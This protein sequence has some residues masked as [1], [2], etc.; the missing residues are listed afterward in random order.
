[1]GCQNVDLVLSFYAFST[2]TQA[3]ALGQGKDAAGQYTHAN[4]EMKERALAKLQE[5]DAK[6]RRYKAPDSLIS[7]LKKL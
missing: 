4:L 3:G 7:F 2:H 6:I 5:P 1:V